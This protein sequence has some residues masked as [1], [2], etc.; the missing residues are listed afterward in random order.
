[1][2]NAAI[3]VPVSEVCGLCKAAGFP[4]VLAHYKGTPKAMSSSGQAVPPMCFD[5]RNGKVPR[6]IQEAQGNGLQALVAEAHRE[7]DERKAA[8]PAPKWTAVL[9]RVAQLKLGEEMEVELPPDSGPN[10]FRSI[11]YQSKLTQGRRWSVNKLDGGKVKVKPIG[12]FDG[13]IPG[14]EQRN[15]SWVETKR[16][17]DEH[18]RPPE[19]EV[20]NSMDKKPHDGAHACAEAITAPVMTRE[21]YEREYG[22]LGGKSMAQSTLDL[23]RKIEALPADSVLILPMKDHESISAARARYYNIVGRCIR[24][25]KPKFKVRM[26]AAQAHRHVVLHKEEPGG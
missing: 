14:M 23:W 4:N 2:S 18:K 22:K 5:H 10:A 13:P 6:F 24:A 11:L 12:S 9:E 3:S 20:V 16:R 7:I 8:R 21:Q 15:R 26:A 17:A 19:P 25:F 1:M